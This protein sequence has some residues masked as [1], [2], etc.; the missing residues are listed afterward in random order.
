MIAQAIGAGPVQAMCLSSD[1]K[2][3]GKYVSGRQSC[4][5]WS[6]GHHGAVDEPPDCGA[7]VRNLYAAE[8]RSQA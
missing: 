4:D 6:S 2:F 8:E 1:G 5:K 3:N 7:V